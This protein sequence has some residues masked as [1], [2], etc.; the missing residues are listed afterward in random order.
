MG[1]LGE[2]CNTACT[3]IG[4]SCV[5]AGAVLGEMLVGAPPFYSRNLHVMYRAILHGELRIPRR[6]L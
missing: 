1:G 6:V 2:T 5:G 3:A 4:G